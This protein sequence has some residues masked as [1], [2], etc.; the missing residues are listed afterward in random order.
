MEEISIYYIYRQKRRGHQELMCIISMAGGGYRRGRG[1]SAM[2][3]GERCGFESV[4]CQMNLG[5]G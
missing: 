3:A 5:L 1:V 4:S 2:E